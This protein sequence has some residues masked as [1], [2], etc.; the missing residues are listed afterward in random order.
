MK[1]TLLNIMGGMDYASQGKVIV[2]EKEISSYLQKQ[3]Q[4]AT[5]KVL[6]FK[7]KQIQ[8]IFIKQNNCIVCIAIVIGLPLGY[9][10][11]DYIYKNAIGDNYDFDASIQTISYLFAIVG[12]FIVSYVMNKVLARKVKTINMVSSLKAN[13]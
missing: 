10:L 4:F 11:V 13:E 1:S 2:D 12:T 3:Y 7:D 6:G 5:M 8:D 9:Y